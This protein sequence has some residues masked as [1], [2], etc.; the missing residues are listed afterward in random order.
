MKQRSSTPSYKWQGI[1]AQGRLQQG[2][3]MAAYSALARAQLQRQGIRV[4]QLHRQWWTHDDHIGAKS[5]ATMTRQW[6]TLIRT[7]ISMVPAL[8]M[9]QRSASTPALATMLQ[10]VRQDVESGM[11]IAQALARHPRGF[12]PLYV[13]MVHAGETAGI[14]DTM[15]ERLAQTLEKNESLRA[16]VRAALIYPATVIV[17]AVAVLLVILL[18]VVPVFE[19]VYRAFGTELPWSTRMVLAL[20]QG[21]GQGAHWTALLALPLLWWVA[22]RWPQSEWQRQWHRR[23]LDWPGIGP[24]VRT[25]VL[26]RWANTL[27]ALL[28]AGVPLAE[29]LPVAGQSTAHPVYARV[30]EHLQRRVA[31]GGRL[32]EGMAHTGRFPELLIQLC[33]TGEDTGTLDVVLEKAAEMMTEELDTRIHMLSSLIEPL[34]IVVLGGSIGVI[35]VAMYLPIFRLGQVF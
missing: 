7:G 9:L 33:T 8:Q 28:A 10:Q 30:N 22:R 23:M 24:M 21:I 25:A 11:P 18:H 3:L 35:L 16:R 27:S 2:S 17:I 6:A 13:S 26:A 31:Q 5:I 19:D 29:A 14:L 12:G 20:S 4:Q 34:I 32:N 1:D 15:I